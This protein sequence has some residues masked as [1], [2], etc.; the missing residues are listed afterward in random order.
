MTVEISKSHKQGDLG[1]MG[2]YTIHGPDKMESFN[3]ELAKHS[4]KSINSE[5]EKFEHEKWYTIAIQVC[6]PFF[7][8]GCGTIGA[9]I[10]M[11]NV[12]EYKV[13]KEVSALYVLV[14]ALLGLKGNLDMCLASRLS[15]QANMGNMKSRNEMIK[16]VVGNIL[17]VQVQSIVASCVVSVFAVSV[18][19]I[20]R[21]NFDWIHTLLLAT[22]S[23]LTATMSCFVLD[24]VLISIILIAKKLNL[25]PD[26]M[27]TPMAASIGDVVS[28][29]ILST[30]A[31]L[32]F[33]IHD[34]YPWLMGLILGTYVIILLPIWILIVRKNEYT[35]EVLAKGWTPVIIALFISGSG[36]L[37]LDHAVDNFNGYTVFQPIINGIGGNL[38]SV[39]ASRTSTILH[40]TSFRGIIPPHTKQFVSPWTAL[41]TGVL[42]AKT[43]R[44]LL[45]ISIPGH[46]VFV[47]LADLIY[48]SGVTTVKVPFVM[49]YIVVG[50]TQL[51]LL[52]YIC[53]IMVHTLWRYKMDPDN[54]AIPYLT[55][56]GDLL[57]SS[58]LLVGFIFLKSIN[59]EYQPDQ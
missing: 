48:N 57:G 3:K 42:P 50:T 12:T 23:T 38:V 16:M 36:G 9:G 43:A 55:S 45:L 58:L 30:W 21:P 32:L 18:S 37:I 20:I 54:N 5:K 53:H 49:T 46:I 59:Q 6:V 13:F 15:T 47:L 44:I 39:Q 10:V 24:M 1:T 19:A 27:A 14:P 51:V 7:I 41:V 4:L 2:V 33:R 8:A 56:L 52:L 26:N 34:Q 25:N 29:I 17:L 31:R 11:A 28:L 35:K 22:S 40:R